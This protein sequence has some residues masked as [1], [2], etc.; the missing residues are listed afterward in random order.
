MLMIRI[1]QSEKEGNVKS[2]LAIPETTSD[3]ITKSK[4]TIT[5]RCSYICDDCSINEDAVFLDAI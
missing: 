5:S 4:S 1:Y 2:V 3:E